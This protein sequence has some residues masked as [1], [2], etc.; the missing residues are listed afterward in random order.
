MCFGHAHVERVLGFCLYQLR[1]L[2][3]VVLMDPTVL[4]MPFQTLGLSQSL[5][6]VIKERLSVLL[7]RDDHL[8][9]CDIVVVSIV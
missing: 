4:A 7:S 2:L 1:D 5:L 3:K 9:S 8:L 6:A